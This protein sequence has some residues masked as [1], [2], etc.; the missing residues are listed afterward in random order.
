MSAPPRQCVRIRR[1]WQDG[2][3]IQLVLPMQIKLRKWEANQNSVS[4]DR[5]PLTYSLKIGE[6]YVPV[7]TSNAAWPACEIHPTSAWNYGLVV[8]ENA[9]ETS[10]QGCAT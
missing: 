10:F 5:G 7:R 8:D 6:K 2:D 3:T 9:P 4:V 1:Q